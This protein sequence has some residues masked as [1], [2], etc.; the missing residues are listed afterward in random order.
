MNQNGK[1]D[2]LVIPNQPGGK[3]NNIIKQTETDVTTTEQGVRE[4]VQEST[5][6]LAETLQQAVQMTRGKDFRIQITEE[7]NVIEKQ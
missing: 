5:R 4:F 1:R 7:I 6:A 3:A 2:V